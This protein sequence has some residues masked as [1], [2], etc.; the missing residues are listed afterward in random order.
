MFITRGNLAICDPTSNNHTFL[1]L[2]E[3]SLY[4]DFQILKNVPCFYT[5]VALSEDHFEIYNQFID[6]KRQV[7][8]V[9]MGEKSSLNERNQHGMGNVCMTMCCSREVLLNLC[10]VYSRSAAILQHD[11]VVRNTALV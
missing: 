3:K 7:V 6:G 11:S 8:A 1:I 9:E 4:G 10:K 2:P 5:V